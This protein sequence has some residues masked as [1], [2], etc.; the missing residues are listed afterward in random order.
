VA[1][2]PFSLEFPAD[3]TDEKVFGPPLPG[4]DMAATETAHD[5]DWDHHEIHEKQGSG[6]PAG[7]ILWTMLALATLALGILKHRPPPAAPSTSASPEDSN[8]FS[9]IRPTDPPP[10]KAAPTGPA[11]QQPMDKELAA[12]L[13]QVLSAEKMK[14][15]ET[16]VLASFKS[17]AST[18]DPDDR[19]LQ[20]LDTLQDKPVMEA[21]MS[22]NPGPVL[23]TDAT[24]TSSSSSPDGTT[25]FWINFTSDR[26]P[27]QSTMRV[28]VLPD[29]TNKF[30]WRLF[31]SAV[32]DK[33]RQFS[34][35]P[36][37]PTSSIVLACYAARKTALTTDSLPFGKDTIAFSLFSH[38]GS[39]P[40][41]V[42]AYVDRTSVVGG[43]VDL[44]VE[45]TIVYPVNCRIAWKMPQGGQ[46][47][48]E[49]QEWE[50]L[51]ALVEPPALPPEEPEEPEVRKAEPIMPEE[52]PGGFFLPDITPPA[53]PGS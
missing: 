25:L 2:E 40:V 17:F 20:L 11:P 46:P 48:I 1:G 35:S 9:K 28:W 31:E 33:L 49:I 12:Q 34:S 13:E 45:Y 24:V 14:G 29:G 19:A 53:P 50:L 41:V 51:P 52:N 21:W 10:E 38:L 32:D 30:E 6:F 22:A 26:N 15:M 8:L 18:T 43:L 5:I 42:D 7:R 39:K 37:N 44:G 16:G 4:I 23:I 27:N 47:F 3:P 36:P